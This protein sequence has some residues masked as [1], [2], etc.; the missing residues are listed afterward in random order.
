LTKTAGTDNWDAGAVSVDRLLGGND[1]WFEMTVA[2]SDKSRMI[3]FSDQDVSAHYNRIDYAIYLVRDGRVVVYENGRNKGVY[4]TYEVGD[5]LGIARVNGAIHYKRN[6]EVIYVSE[7]VSTTDLMIDV[8]L[9]DEDGKVSD[10]V[11][12]SS[13]PLKFYVV[14]SGNWNDGSIWSM[15]PGGA[16]LGSLPG[17]N[18]EVFIDGYEVTIDTDADCGGILL[19]NENGNTTLS[20]QAGV[21]TSH[22]AIQIKNRSAVH[23]RCTFEV[24][25]TG[26]VNVKDR[27]Q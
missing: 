4:G 20:I 16:P 22:R 15:N 21:L 13:Q 17:Q 9:R 1:G 12:S 8:S 23:E 19:S 5:R 18:A 10:V 7:K 24:V 14:S 26:K 2:Q 6:D 27:L 11:I 3:G 25:G